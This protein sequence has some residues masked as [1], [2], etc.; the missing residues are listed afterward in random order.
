MPPKNKKQAG[1]GSSWTLPK[2][3]VNA[4][5]YHTLN[6]LHQVGAYWASVSASSSTQA[7]VP[8]GD[9][10]GVGAGDLMD[11]ISKKAVM[12]LDVGVKRGCC[13]AC[14]VVLVPGLTARVRVRGKF[15]LS[16]FSA[17]NG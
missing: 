8:V 9:G 7:K 12:R 10:V 1:G 14:G 3:V 16:P 5:H 2:S 15:W 13:R 4:E 17:W 11:K 6:H